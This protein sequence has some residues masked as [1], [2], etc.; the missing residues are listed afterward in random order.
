MNIPILQ[1]Y[2]YPSKSKTETNC[3]IVIISVLEIL[4]MLNE[5]TEIRERCE[6]FETLN[7]EKTRALTTELFFKKP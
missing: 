6:K 4:R 5:S 1:Y 7:Q 3:N 2:V